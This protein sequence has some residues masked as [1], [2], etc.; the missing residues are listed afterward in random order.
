MADREMEITYIT[1]ENAQLFVSQNPD[2]RFYACRQSGQ[3]APRR[4]I[5]T[6]IK[7]GG[8]DSLK[9]AQDALG[10][11][12]ANKRENGPSRVRWEVLVNGKRVSW[13]DYH[14]MCRGEML[15]PAAD[16]APAALVSLANIEYRIAQHIQG[17]YSN[18]LEVGR[19][20]NEA[21][22]SGLVPHGQ[23]E[24]WVRANAHMS[25]RQAQKLMQAARS[26][27]AGSALAQLPI[28][29]IQ[30]ILSLP[31]PERESMAQRAQDEDMALR[32]LQEA[33]AREKQ[34]ADQ[35]DA[36]ARRER[37]RADTLSSL[38]NEAI[39]AASRQHK[40]AVAAQLEAKELRKQLADVEARA[41]EPVP[42]QGIS[43]E[44]QAQIDAL[45]QE[46]KYAEEAV[47]EQAELRAEAQAKLLE[48]QAQAARSPGM[49]S[50][51]RLDLPAAVRAFIGSAG[52]LPH[53]GAQIASLSESERQELR[54]H[55]DM[56]AQWVDGA[57]RVLALPAVIIE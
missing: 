7:D 51:P 17:A 49:G 5:S 3:A 54:A 52:T 35:A 42:A 12:V 28:S 32:E 44:A 34:R 38:Q 45:R 29:K 57:R 33:V 19:C 50:S 1:D 16:Q 31:E 53:M 40:E 15:A 18:M 46:L 25:E 27:R 56:I 20:L 8:Y 14:A 22:E 41:S 6:Y 30:A 11:Y 39:E 10:L 36:M 48:Q 13:D 9:E 4:L 26:V 55:V 37:E 47:E 24:S 21:K 23:W 43:A 2:G